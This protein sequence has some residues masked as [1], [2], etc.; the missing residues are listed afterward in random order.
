[1]K[2]VART[3]CFAFDTATEEQVMHAENM[4]SFAIAIITALG[5]LLA[6]VPIASAQKTTQ[7]TGTISDGSTI[8]SGLV[9]PPNN[10]CKLT[11]V[12]VVGNMQVGTGATLLVFPGFEQTVTIDGNIAA[13]GC[14]SV[15][16]AG[17]FG[18]ISVGGNVTIQ[19]CTSPTE[20]GTGYSGNVT[21][22]GN[23]VCT[24]NIL[25]TAVAG[26]V[27]GNL[28]IDN[29]NQV[30]GPAVDVEFNEISGNADVSGNIGTI[31]PLLRSNTIGGNLRCFDNSPPPVDGGLQN[32]VGGSKRG[33]CANF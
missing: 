6:T 10:A 4:K 14:K 12:T 23:F 20:S 3:M 8:D 24:N 2:R 22:S 28:T 11:N 1:M 17:D 21:I 26:I 30:F 25:C 19:N 5:F 31:T 33:Q 27:E 13:G 15:F 7:C 16:L 9:V 18:V 29:N 32:T